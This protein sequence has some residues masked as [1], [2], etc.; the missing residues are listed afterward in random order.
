MQTMYLFMF[1][2]DYFFTNIIIQSYIYMYV[3]TYLQENGLELLFRTGIAF[4]GYLGA[5]Q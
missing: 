5:Q 4:C 1:I 3:Y 2:S